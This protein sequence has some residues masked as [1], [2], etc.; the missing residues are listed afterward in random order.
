LRVSKV[1]TLG[2]GGIVVALALTINAHR[3]SDIFTLLNQFMVSIAFPLTVPVFL[4]LFIK[5][6]PP[7][8]AWASALAAFVYSA[9]ANFSFAMDVNAADFAVRWPG[10]AR[11]FF[12]H[13]T[14]T[15]AAAERSDLLLGV[16]ALG[17]VAVGTAVF[18]ASALFYRRSDVGHVT[19]LDKLFLK[20][21]T[22]LPTLSNETNRED[23]PIYRLLGQLCLV[24]GGF[25]VMLVLIPNG[26]VGRM[27]FVFVGAI[28]AGA[29]VVLRAIAKRKG[30]PSSS[31][32]ASL[33]AED[34]VLTQGP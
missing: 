19:R 1:C 22:P 9:W 16:T 20:L 10:M 26:W 17:T 25:V 3:T 2:F 33:R 11:T 13:V 28:I 15:L 23:E 6:T 8:S 14:G 27:C 4:G 12:G 21:R 24:Y 7:W 32:G 34:D 5:R 18:L 29:G 31:P 30:Q